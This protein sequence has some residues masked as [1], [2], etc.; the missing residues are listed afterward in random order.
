MTLHMLPRPV[1]VDGTPSAPKKAIVGDDVEEEMLNAAERGDTGSP[2]QEEKDVVP[3]WTILGPCAPRWPPTWVG[4]L[5]G[6]E[7][8]NELGIG[9]NIIQDLLFAPDMAGPR[10][11]GPPPGA[12]EPRGSISDDDIVERKNTVF[13]ANQITPILSPSSSRSSSL[14]L[15]SE[16]GKRIEQ[17]RDPAVNPMALMHSTAAGLSERTDKKKLQR[18]KSMTAAAASQPAFKRRHSSLYY[19][20]SYT[21]L[22]AHETPEHLVCRLLLEKKKQKKCM[23][24]KAKSLRDQ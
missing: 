11:N 2:H 4:Q 23:P 7:A 12:Y 9:N 3:L 24:K 16:E 18:R 1:R 15:G 22:R 10:P 19:P 14:D 17:L 5:D 20:V 8:A 21:H 6:T 13:E